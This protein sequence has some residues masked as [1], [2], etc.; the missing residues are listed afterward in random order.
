MAV[1]SRNPFG[2]LQ[3]LGEFECLDDLEQFFESAGRNGV[4]LVEIGESPEQ[5]LRRPGSGRIE[6]GKGRAPCRL[7]GQARRPA[8]ERDRRNDPQRDG[9]AG[10]S[11]HGR[12]NDLS[13]ISHR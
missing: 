7:P 5:L 2:R 1:E 6:E 3:G 11:A 9:K 4:Q 8:G 13:A 12:D 10:R